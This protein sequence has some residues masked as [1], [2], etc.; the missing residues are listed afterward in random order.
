MPSTDAKGEAMKYTLFLLLLTVLSG[1]SNSG[2][3]KVGPDTYYIIKKAGSAFNTGDHDK[4]VILQ[5]ANAFCE[6]Q[7][8]DVVV[9]KAEAHHGIA[10]A[11][12]ASADATFK[13]VPKSR[14]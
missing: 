10:F 6:Q 11:R 9:E 13:C 5:Q 8:R 2:P 3:I 4:V 7:G 12:V 14:P 1:C